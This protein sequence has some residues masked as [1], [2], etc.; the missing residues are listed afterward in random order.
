MNL[1]DYF[2]SNVKRYPDKTALICQSEAVT[3]KDLQC[4]S[5]RLAGLLWRHGVRKGSKV[6]VLLHNSMDF[7]L[8]MLAAAKLGAVIVPMNPTLPANHVKRAFSHADVEFVITRT[9][10][11]IRH[12][13]FRDV[14]PGDK[15]LSIDESL[16]RNLMQN[17]GDGQILPT[18]P[19][20]VEPECDYLITMTS[21]ST[22]EP[23]PIVLSQ[24]TKIKRSLEG[25]KNF[26]DLSDSEVI[27]IGSPMYHSL[28][29]RLT[30]LPLLIGGTGVILPKF[31]PVLWLETVQTYGITFTI[32]VS[33]QLGMILDEIK[34]N[35]YNLTS[36]RKIVSSSAALDAEIKGQLLSKLDCEFHE[37]YGTS[38]IGIA[39]NLSPQ[40]SAKKLKSV[41]KP[42]PYVVLKIVD[43]DDRELPIGNEG[44]IVCKT[45]TAFSGYYKKHEVTERSMRGGYFHTGDMG[46]LD[47]DGFLYYLGRKD[48]VIIT[49]AINV[50]PR[51]IEDVL[52]SFEGIRESAVIGV[53]DS[54]FGEAILAV[55]VADKKI[56]EKQLRRYC[57]Q[58][59][60]DYQQPMAY[61]FVK[62]LPK[63]EMGKIIK[64]KLKDQFHGYDATAFLRK[65]MKGPHENK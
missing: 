4:C 37:C 40:D 18:L 62:E 56:D 21:G 6:A 51:D 55:I 14:L 38:E 63:N 9:E 60:A 50:Y 25:A 30:W 64:R 41:G 61:E 33:S 52:A 10:T 7:A 17:G 24:K 11:S 20:D 49:G 35:S 44:E 19:Y 39:T 27:L 22:S 42:L 46:K 48:D 65:I 23:K 3:Y 53:A 36:L 45:A 32:A 43:E 58:Y 47:E 34:T 59:L 54:H 15:I 1:F 29:F 28:A 2:A 57:A 31:R 5:I 16:S 13:N 26:Y 12:E 8:C